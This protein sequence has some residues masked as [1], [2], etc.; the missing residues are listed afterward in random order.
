MR[1]STMVG[2]RSHI[3][4]VLFFVDLLFKESIAIAFRDEIHP[5][6]NCGRCAGTS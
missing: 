5:L 4:T 2:K 1:L 6:A 3:E